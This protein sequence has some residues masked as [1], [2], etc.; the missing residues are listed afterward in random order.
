M[1][2]SINVLEAGSNKKLIVWDSD[3]KAT[4]Y[5]VVGMD[6]LFNILPI[7]IVKDNKLVIAKKDL[8]NYIKVCVKYMF[9]DKNSGKEFV[10]ETTNYFDLTKE[11][12]NID[13]KAIKSYK[14]ISFS[15]YSEEVYDKYYVYERKDNEDIL[16]IETEDFQV[17][18]DSF[19]EGNTYYV[20]AYKKHDDI[21]ELS[22]KS[23]VYT[24][25]LIKRKKTDK[26]DLSVVIPAFNSELFLSRT[27]DSVLLSTLEYLEIIIVNDGSTDNSKKVMDWYNRK[28]AGIVHVKHQENKGLS[29]ARNVGIKMA[30]GE[31]IAFLDSDDM[32]HPNMYKL[33]VDHGHIHRL[34]C[35]IGKVLIRKNI[36]DYY[37]YL[38]P[39]RDY[40]ND[41]II[42]TFEEMIREKE[43]N[44]YE[45]I[46]FVSPCNKILKTSLVKEHPFPDLNRYEDNAYTMMI[47]SYIDKFGFCKKA[48]YMWDQRFRSTIGTYSSTYKMVSVVLMNICFV[49]ASFNPSKCGNVKRLTYLAYHSV[50]EVYRLLTDSNTPLFANNYVWSY[51]Q[52]IKE[53]NKRID[54]LKNP[55]I[56]N[57]KELFSF[58]EKAL[59]YKSV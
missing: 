37:F 21:Y 6:G 38:N 23:D 54:L 7:K 41:N 3:E 1:S 11:L 39:N 12:N 28:Y 33:L 43:K 58:V 49:T 59:N 57:K 13:I 56:R 18:S 35:V 8:E 24:C 51:V 45:N 48:Y 10:L 26:I 27:I 22:A 55:Y 40:G 47:Y 32:V 30:K 17:S 19:K 4:Y 2:K 46:F 14:G 16:L 9:K 31:Y 5:E 52:E 42:Y 50:N 36:N 15:L 20:E 53:L 44:S 34:D 29:L 25:T